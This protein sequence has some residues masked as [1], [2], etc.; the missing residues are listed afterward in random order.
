[1]IADDEKEALVPRKDLIFL[2]SSTELAV[3]KGEFPL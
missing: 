3:A 2:L 1:M